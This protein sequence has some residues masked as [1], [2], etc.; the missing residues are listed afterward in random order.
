MPHTDACLIETQTLTPYFTSPPITEMSLKIIMIR[1]TIK[2]NNNLNQG[3]T[4]LF[5]STNNSNVI[6]SV[7]YILFFFCAVESENVLSAN[8]FQ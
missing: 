6:V 7:V 5:L 8:L 4:E 1:G 2:K 3:Y